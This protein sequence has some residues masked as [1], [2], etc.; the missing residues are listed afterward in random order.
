MDEPRDHK[1]AVVTGG[2]GGGI[3]CGISTVLAREGWQVLIVDIDEAAATGLVDR[4]ER[5]G[6]Q[7]KAM[8]ADL[9]DDA[10]PDAIVEASLNWGG[11]ID[12]LV[13]NAGI[14]VRKPATDVTDAEYDR[15]TAL[16]LRAIFRISRA[17]AEPLGRRGGAIVSISS[18]HAL[19]TIGGYS[20][21]AATKAAIQGLTRGLAVDLGDRDIRVNCV[22]PGLVDSPQS[23][24]ILAEITDDAEAWMHDF[25]N[26]RQ[27][28]RHVVAAEEVGDLVAFLLGDRARSLTGQSFVIDGGLTALLFD[29]EAEP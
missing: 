2:A 14:S 15:V 19:A 13:H 21:Y 7:V 9:T 27:A 5:E 20:V 10:T 29:R 26:R 3:G 1:L 24:R 8:V 23:R 17:A 28:L 16:N 25:V 22:L 4:L 12:G 11:R 18:V 6:L